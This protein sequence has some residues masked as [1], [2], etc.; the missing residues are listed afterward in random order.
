MA[1]IANG[2]ADLANG[3]DE[4]DT[5]HPLGR[6]ELDLA[7]KLVDVLDQRT[8]D[9]ASALRRLGAH[10]VDHIGREVRVER[11]S[12]RHGDSGGGGDVCSVSCWSRGGD[13]AVL[14]KSGER[15]EGQQRH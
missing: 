2:G 4:L 14:G 12:G 1:F 15:L 7:G 3:V 13:E 9:D 8:K 11:A 5:E 6:G 10:G